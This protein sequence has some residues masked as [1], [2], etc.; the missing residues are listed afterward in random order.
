[1]AIRPPTEHLENPAPVSG[2]EAGLM[3]IIGTFLVGLGF[4]IA[5]VRNNFRELRKASA[6]ASGSRRASDREGGRGPRHP[7]NNRLYHD[8]KPRTT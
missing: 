1:M 7:R 3:L 5:T 4:G 6:A 8:R 2:A